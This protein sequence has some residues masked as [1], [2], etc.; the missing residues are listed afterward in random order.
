[1]DR[2]Y[3]PA[4]QWTGETL[5]LTGEEGHHAVRVMRKSVGD[6]VE[7]FDGEGRAAGGR[8]TAVGKAAL[9]IRLEREYQRKQPPTPITLAVA[10]T[11][12]KTM[13]LIVQKAVELGVSSIQPLATTHTVVRLSQK[14]RCDKST[15][16]QRVALEA[17]KQCGQ[18]HLPRVEPVIDIGEY[19][20]QDHRGSRLI[21][22]L[23]SG[24]RG[25]REHLR[26]L[27]PGEPIHLLVGPEGDFTQEETE[28]ALVAGYQPVTLGDIVLRVETACLYLISAVRY[29]W[30]Q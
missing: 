9:S 24:T 22:S 4:A 17:C 13:D 3:L 14:D 1:M 30:S 25:L 20:G 6:A 11:K 23:A 10:M 29:E 26:G 2:F 19:I 28:A 7:L 27:A 16:W 18:D 21:A 15:K 12:G 5:Q 8:V